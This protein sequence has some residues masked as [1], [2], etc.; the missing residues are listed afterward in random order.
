MPIFKENC[1]FLFSYF[2]TTFNQERVWGREYIN[3]F[4]LNLVP[5][6]IPRDT[7]INLKKIWLRSTQLNVFKYETMSFYLFTVQTILSIQAGHIL[8]RNVPLRVSHFL[9]IA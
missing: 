2:Q 8:K 6:E 4:P 1:A 9:T 3:R 7:Q 5:T